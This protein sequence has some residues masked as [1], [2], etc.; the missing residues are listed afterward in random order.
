MDEG[1]LYERALE[2]GRTI[3]IFPLTYDRARIGIGRGI[4][5]DDVW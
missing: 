1:V 5:M 3:F 4:G 2:D